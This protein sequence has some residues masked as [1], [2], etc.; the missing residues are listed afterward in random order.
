VDDHRA[1][2]REHTDKSHDAESTRHLR[3]LVVT[4]SRLVW[5]AERS[6]LALAPLL[7][8]RGIQL[9]LGSPRAGALFEAW[10]STGLPHVA[11]TLPTHL[12]IRSPGGG[13][14]GV[15]ALLAEVRST[16]EGARVVSRACGP[17]DVVHSNSLWGHL[18]CALGGRLA[19][20]PVVVELHDLVRPGLGR[21]VLKA[22]TA[23]STGVISISQAVARTAGKPNGGSPGKFWVIPQAVDTDRF[24]PGSAD[25]KLRARLGVD[26]AAP[27]VGIVGRIDPEKGVDVVVR[28]LAALTGEGARCQLAVIGGSGLDSGAYEA[29]VRAEAGDLLGDRVRFT[30]PLDDVPGALRS[31]DVVIN[32]SAAEPFGLS[33]LEAQAS[34]VAV[35]G[36]AAGGIPEFVNDGETG[37]LVPPGD[38][39]AL[40]AAL[41][42]L[43]DD[44]GLR[45]RLARKGR[46]VAEA[47]YGLAS[48]ADAI[49]GVYRSVSKGR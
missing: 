34:G 25:P 48:R 5:G 4:S 43:L 21:H 30:G 20:R 10:Q 23:L 44:A 2:I 31:L 40:A 36:T 32:A 3:V 1:L 9:T 22:A 18:D 8:A 35:I 17:M 29:W 41:R 39:I 11:L 46:A 26:P 47:R 37:L 16:L 28:A 33:V 42:R 24:R 38:P 19:R 49:A 15:P 14:P 6:I 7:E 12:G 45:E 13:R 27:T